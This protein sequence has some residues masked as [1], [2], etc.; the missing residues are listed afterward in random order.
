M[1]LEIEAAF[2]RVGDEK[3]IGNEVQPSDCFEN[4]Y[5]SLVFFLQLMW[6]AQAFTIM[7]SAIV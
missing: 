7:K 1:G 4:T 5:N 3:V 2:G 6:M